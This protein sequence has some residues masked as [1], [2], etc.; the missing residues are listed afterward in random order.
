VQ[1][2]WPQTAAIFVAALVAL[3]CVALISVRASQSPTDYR[4]PTAPGAGAAPLRT[5]YP[6]G[7]IGA[8]TTLRRVAVLKDPQPRSVAV[9]AIRT[10]ILLPALDRRGNYLKVLTP[11]ERIGWVP[12]SALELHPQSKGPAHS[13]GA[14]T[15]VIDPGHG[16]RESG[17][18]GPTGLKESGVNLDI[19]R[20]LARG[21]KGPRVF[22]TRSDEYIA[23]L[24]FRATVANSLKADVFLSVHNNAQPDI[25]SAKP[26]TETYYQARS[27]ASKRLAGLTYEELLRSLRKLPVAWVADK[28]AGA[29]YRTN[30]A[31]LDFYGVLRRSH[32][33]AVISESLFISNAPEEALLRKDAT[34][35]TIADALAR[36]VRRYIE[37][38]DPGSGFVKP[39]LKNEGS[40]FVM[41]SNC[42]DPS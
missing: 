5:H 22:I 17:A 12:I 30:P 9:S 11:C 3:A 10:G 28:D 34:R 32:S 37:T 7:P 41:P 16:G 18:T 33:P 38:S 14:A 24:L 20:R 23:G 36:A 39:L 4:A 15:I 29:K 6:G 27:A 25:R 42:V 8:I 19:A 40:R 26:G 1:P 2:R 13:L 21:L 31:G 35:Q